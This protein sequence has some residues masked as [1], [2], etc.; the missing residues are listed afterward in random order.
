MAKRITA[1]LLA[2]MMVF[3]LSL[4]TACGDDDDNGGG[5]LPIGDGAEEDEGNS[6]T[7]P[8]GS[9]VEL[10]EAIDS[11]ITVSPAAK[12]ILTELGAESKIK[13]N[14]Q[15]SVD[16]TS[17]IVTDAPQ[18]VIY[19]E[20]AVIDVAEIESKG[21][22]AI[23]LP[24]ADS[25]ATVKNHITFIGKMLG[26]A[27]ESI[28]DSITNSLTTMQVATVEW[29]KPTVYFELGSGDDGYYTVAPY[30]YVYELIASAGGVNIFGSDSEYE[31]FVTVTAD[32]IVS[33]NPAVIFTVGSVE[34]ITSREGWSEIDA[35]V[36]GY[37]YSIE[38]LN[39]S[40]DAVTAAQSINDYLAD[41]VYGTVG[42]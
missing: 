22:V 25:M 12:S 42:Q 15:P 20:G 3:S 32:E 18:V 24:T 5:G 10:P 37:V 17:A 8:D 7:A 2:M 26:V 29:Q 11:I 23:K 33:A 39:P 9:T 28:V 16:N 38:N 19:D 40:K 34:D 6:L 36:N 30:S 35:V 1:L 27:T 14:Y 31:G 41:I 4:L 13:A 21:I